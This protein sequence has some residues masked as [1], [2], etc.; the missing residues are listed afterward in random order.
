M[1]QVSVGRECKSRGRL[2][3]GVERDQLTSNILDR[4]FGGVLQLLPSARTEFVDLRRLAV[5]RFVARDAVQRV[6]IDQQHVA[7]AI[8]QLYRFEEF[9]IFDRLDQTAEASHAVIDVNNIVAH[10]QGVQLG[11]RKAL[12]ASNFATQTIAVVAVE[13]LVI[14]IAA[15]FQS[16]PHETLVQRQRQRRKAHR[17]ASRLAENVGQTLYLRLVLRENIRCETLHRACRKIVGQQCKVL[18]ESGLGRSREVHR[19]LCR[20]SCRLGTVHQHHCL[21]AVSHKQTARHHALVNLRGLVPVAEQAF[22]N[23]VHSAHG[24]QRII[25]PIADLRTCKFGHRNACLL[26]LAQVGNDL[27]AIQTLLRQLR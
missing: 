11:H 19:A 15:D 22:A 18:I 23:V 14:G 2:A 13:N 8:D 7:I 27:D 16:G 4:L 24:V 9:A 12:I 6:D 25:N 3:L 17:G 10:L 21:A 26:Y 20:A 5:A 1:L